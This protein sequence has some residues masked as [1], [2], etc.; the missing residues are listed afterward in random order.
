MSR[1]AQLVSIANLR[2]VV[3]GIEPDLFCEYRYRN[4]VQIWISI[5]PLCVPRNSLRSIAFCLAQGGKK[6]DTTAVSCTPL[7]DQDPESCHVRAQ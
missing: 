5:M 7:H 6:H 2:T 4:E 3:G 1:L